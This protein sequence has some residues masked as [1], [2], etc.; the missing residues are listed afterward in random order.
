MPGMTRSL[1]AA[2]LS[3]A[4][5][6]A[7]P[8]LAQASTSVGP[9]SG[10]GVAARKLASVVSLASNR[11]SGGDCAVQSSGS[12]VCWGYGGEGELGNGSTNN[13]DIPVAVTGITNAKAVASSSGGGSFCAL[14]SSGKLKCWGYNAY[15]ELGD[16]TTAPS[17][18]PVTVR[19]ITTAT[20]VVGGIQYFCALLSGGSVDCWGYGV[21]GELG[22]GSTTSSDVPVSVVGVSNAASLTSGVSSTCARLSA[23]K[24]KCWGT[25]AHGALGDGNT[26]NSDVP[27]AVKGLSDAKTVVGGSE[28]ADYCALLTTSHVDCW[29]YGSDGELGNGTT[30]SSDVPVSV[31]GISNASAVITTIGART[32]CVRLST[33]KAKCW[34]YN[35]YGELGD[36]TTAS[37]DV[38][39]SVKGLSSVSAVIGGYFYICA[40]L[41]T[42]Q[43]DCWGY[44]SDGELGNGSTNNS[45]VPVQVQN[46][47][48]ATN[49]STAYYSSCARLS[50]GTVKCW[51]SGANGA[52]GDGNTNNSDVP[53]SVVSPS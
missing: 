30:T 53:V 18:V 4:V 40:L 8:G 16:E 41:S 1:V 32:V 6:V 5:L 20:A 25:G 47:S 31:S 35:V 7:V 23:G 17:D 11:P 3:A 15:G 39:V 21:D 49:V 38:P 44:G 22:N 29:G 43:I 45:D 28:Y 36:G 13:S 9:A 33:G 46:L 48:N 51:G 14:L 34:G 12:V 27:E 50:T 37:S 26:N 24:V 2:V 52:L 42:S 10:S 19:N